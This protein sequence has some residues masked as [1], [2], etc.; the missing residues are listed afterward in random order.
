VI[1]TE[2]DRESF[3]K[4]RLGFCREIADVSGGHYYHLNALGPGTL[5]SITEQEIGA[6][7]EVS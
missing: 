2:E 1:D 4:L 7:C 3:V 6:L 5:H